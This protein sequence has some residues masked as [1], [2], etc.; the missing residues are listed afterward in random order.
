MYQIH[1]FNKSLVSMK[2]NFLKDTDGIVGNCIAITPSLTFCSQKIWKKIKI[3]AF[4]PELGKFRK[5]I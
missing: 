4:P 3:W 5:E 1:F 2:Q